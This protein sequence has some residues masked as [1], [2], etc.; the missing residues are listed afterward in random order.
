MGT[1]LFA[2]AA[3][4]EPD[5]RV[6]QGISVGVSN[7]RYFG[8]LRPFEQATT[9]EAAYQR[10]LGTQG[11]GQ[12]LFVGGGLRFAMPTAKI[13]FPLEVFARGELRT[14]LGFW[15]PAAGLEL[16]FSQVA[17]PWR[18][19][20]IP[21]ANEILEAEDGRNGPLY[22]AIHAAPLRFHFGRFVVGTLEVQWGPSGPPFGTVQRLHLGLARVEMQL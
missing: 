4:A 18:R 14:R 7:F 17:L 5:Q 3:M 2:S 21:F 22:F 12:N 16:G 8:L 15:E 9:M 13:N 10:A 20:R 11:L 6:A 1:L 19:L